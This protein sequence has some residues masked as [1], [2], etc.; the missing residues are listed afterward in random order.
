MFNNTWY[1]ILQYLVWLVCDWK[2]YYNVSLNSGD[3]TVNTV[4]LL[5]VNFVIDYIKPCIMCTTQ[6]AELGSTFMSAQS[7]VAAS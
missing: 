7:Y 3:S 1:T 6:W 2:M 5:S 4:S